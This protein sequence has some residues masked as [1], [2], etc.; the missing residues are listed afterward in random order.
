MKPCRG[1]FALLFLAAIFIQVLTPVYSAHA[2]LGIADIVFDVPTEAETTL[3]AASSATTAGGSTATAV[4]SGATAGSTAAT[5]GT[6]GITATNTA[7]DTFWKRVL[8]VAAYAAINIVLQTI[9]NQ[10]I[11]WIKGTDSNFVQN[12]QAEAFRTADAQTGKLLNELTGVNLCGNIGAF[13][14]LSI[15]A[16]NAAFRQRL[17]CSVT[18]IVG[19]FQNFYDNFANGGW[20]AFFSISL[21]PQNNAYGAFLLTANE[22]FQ[23]QNGAQQTLQQKLIQGSGF[24]G[25][26]VAREANCQ[27]VSES[28]AKAL[29]EST[30]VQDQTPSAQKRDK[31]EESIKIERAD[32]GS[33]MSAKF[34]DVQYDTKTP[35]K[36]FADALPAATFSGLRRT[37]LANQIDQGIAQIITAL[38]QRI[39]KES[40]SGGQGLFGSRDIGN[41]PPATL[42]DA[43]FH[44]T[45]LTSQ[46]DDSSLRLEASLSLLDTKI[47]N[48]DLQIASTTA[49][50]QA[51]C[52]GHQSETACDPQQITTKGSPQEDHDKQVFGLQIDKVKTESTSL[53][54]QR[55][56][57][58]ER[59]G[60]AGDALDQILDLRARL[61]TT[62]DPALLENLDTKLIGAQTDAEQII[63]KAG[64]PPVGQ[65]GLDPDDNFVKIADNAQDRATAI[66]AY[67][68]KQITAQTDT[69][70]KAGLTKA[71]DDLKKLSDDLGKLRTD[72]LAAITNQTG[73]TSIMTKI[74]GKITGINDKILSVY[75]L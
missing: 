9:T 50:L 26:E 3:I 38:L 54:E 8:N 10:I 44:P 64:G 55:V 15:G 28:D 41:P 14:K 45:Y 61:L 24:K 68:E 11:G 59:L 33:F 13:L 16:P 37:E 71:R 49:Q 1:A 36:L 60:K 31:P 46:T 25:F 69:T 40:V 48:L 30:L 7:A 2:V 47:Q 63:Q 4:S 27:D 5:A 51:A 70:K 42:A 23:R 56:K 72:F 67:L 35:G 57:E 32:D 52:V 58:V 17:Q 6:S 39:I 75:S 65:N 19:N 20:P 34:C 43:G 66:V 18:G 21:E 62:I 74:T 29:Q 73:T 22:Q 12:L 53:E